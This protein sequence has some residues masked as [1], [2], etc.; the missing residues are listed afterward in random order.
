MEILRKALADEKNR[1]NDYLNQLKYLQ[2]D[3]ENLQKRNRKELDVT[4]QRANENLISKLLVIFD[5]MELALNS[6]LE[7]ENYQQLKSGFQLIL[8]KMQHILEKEGLV[9][10]DALGKKFDP[11]HHEA[12]DQTL[13]DDKPDGLIMEEMKSGYTFKGKLLRSSLVTIAKNL[14][15]VREKK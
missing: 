3:M 12:V 14:R 9:R 4:V 6:T 1:S 2:A 7:V 10:I 15:E 8:D 5:D 13:R 11:T